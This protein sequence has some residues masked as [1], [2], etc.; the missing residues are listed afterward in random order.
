MALGLESALN[1]TTSAET[2]SMVRLFINRPC[3]IPNTNRNTMIY[4]L[5]GYVDVKMDYHSI[6]TGDWCAASG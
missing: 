1:S 6:I 2:C 4:T 5:F 3:R